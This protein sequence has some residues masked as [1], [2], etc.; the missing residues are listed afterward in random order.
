MER[1]KRRE[2]KRVGR[3]G[4]DI[5]EKIGGVREEGERETRGGA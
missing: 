4:I 3:L 1:E 5:E 2:R